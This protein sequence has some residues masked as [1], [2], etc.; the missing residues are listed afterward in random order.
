MA[1]SYINEMSNY[2]KKRRPSLPLRFKNT[3]FILLMLPALLRHCHIF[4]NV[5]FI[6]T[7][8]CNN[9]NKL[10]ITLKFTLAKVTFN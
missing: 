4:K 8:G 7:L 1:T 9:K 6:L 10:K 3:C 2:N 5:N